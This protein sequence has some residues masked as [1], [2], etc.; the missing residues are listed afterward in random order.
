[1]SNRS[2]WL[3][4]AVT[5]VDAMAIVGLMPSP[6]ELAGDLADPGTWVAS[7]GAD[8]AATALC[9]AALWCV[10]VW[11][12]L[13]LLAA[14]TARLPGSVG[15]VADVACRRLLPR[16]LYRVVAVTAGVGVVLA[17]L[18]AG[19]RAPQP[20]GSVAADR[21]P[22]ASGATLPAP[23][24]PTDPPSSAANPARPGAASVEHR[25]RP[26]DSL[27]RITAAA[28]GPAATSRDVAAAWPT[29]YAANRVT[30]GPDPDLIKPGQ[31]LRLPDDLKEYDR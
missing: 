25:V 23:A 10:A 31:L 11:L 9:E 2:S 4:P 15:R 21:L 8:S 19:A 29:V 17:P 18:A 12:G 22:A 3:Y 5:I 27:W 14:L 20:G 6:H 16:T 24:W 1:M 30:I 13:G 7:A 28:L 26:G